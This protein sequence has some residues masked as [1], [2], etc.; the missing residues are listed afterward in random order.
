MEE[1]TTQLDSEI[2]FSEPLSNSHYGAVGRNVN[3]F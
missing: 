2:F 1:Y 3:D